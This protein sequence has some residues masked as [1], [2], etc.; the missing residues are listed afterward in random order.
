MPR[1][2]KYEKKAFESSGAA[3]DV[4]ANLYESMLLSDA[5]LHL[6]IQQQRLYLYCKLQ[7]YSEKIKPIKDDPTSFTMN[8]A[9]W[10]T[11]YQ[12]YDKRNAKGFQ[13][14]LKAL[15]DHGFISCVSSGANTRTKSIYRFSSMWRKFGTDEFVISVH[16]M[17]SSMAKAF[18]EHKAEED[19]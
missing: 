10:S 18:R 9:K 15:I 17:T 1:K 7:F 19:R 12:L 3:S 2:S 5:W 16:D 4:S 13:R 6:T 8:Q 11:K 14:D